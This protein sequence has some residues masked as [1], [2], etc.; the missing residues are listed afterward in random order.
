MSIE[1]LSGRTFGQYQLRELMGSGGM[2]AVYRAYQPAL[3]REVAFKVLSSV[4]ASHP[5]SIERFLREAQT[6][7]ALEHNHIV[8]I[9]D[10]GTYDNVT[11][12]VMRLLTGGSLAERMERQALTHQPLPTLIEI[13]GILN[14]LASALDYAHSQGV[15]HRDIKAS[16]VMFNNQG[17]AFLVDFGIVKL[18]DAT[19]SLTNENI[20]L[21]TPSYMS[22]EQWRGDPVTPAVDQYALGVLTYALVTGKLPFEAP[23]PY[24]MMHKHLNEI[25]TPP[26][27]WRAGLPVAVKYVL[28]RAM[29]KRPQERFPT[30]TAF[31][32][33]FAQ[34]IR[35]IEGQSTGFFT[36]PI[37]PTPVRS[38][39]TTSGT[40]ASTIGDS[41]R[42]RRNGGR[43]PLMVGLGVL[44]VAL[45]GIGIMFGALRVAPEGTPT[46]TATD[47]QENTQESFVL[48]PT[49]V[50]PTST[51][52]P[53]PSSTVTL[54][55]TNTPTLTASITPSATST[56]TSTA[57]STPKAEEIAGATYAAIQAA[58]LAALPATITPD[59]TQTLHAA[60]TAF[61]ERDLTLTATQWTSTPTPSPS[62]T[63]TATPTMIPVLPSATAPINVSV[64][65]N[66]VSWNPIQQTLGDA[67]M[68]L[69][70][71]GCFE[72]G[73]TQLEVDAALEQCEANLGAGQCNREWFEKESPTQQVCFQNPFW[74][75][76]LEVT[77]GQYGSSSDAFG[78]NNAQYPREN[79]SWFE[80]KSFCERRGAR[81]PTEAEW[82]YAARGPDGLS[83][84]WGDTFIADNS[85]Y[86]ANSGEHPANVGSRERGVSWVGALDMS[87]NI[88]EWT[89]TIFDTY[90]YDAND[91]RE[92]T[93]DATSQRVIRGGSWL[94]IPVSL[95][96]AD[97]AGIDPDVRDG[98]IGFRCLRD[99]QSH[100][101]SVTVVP[102]PTSQPPTATVFVPLIDCLGSPPSRLYVGMQATVLDTEPNSI[103]VRPQSAE[104]RGQ[105]FAGAI[106]NIIGGPQCDSASRLTWWQ[107]EYNGVTG[108]TAE[109]KGDVYWIGP[110]E[111]GAAT[112]PLTPIASANDTSISLPSCNVIVE[113][114]FTGADAT[115]DWY[116]GETDSSHVL[117]A[118]GAYE[119]TLKL[120][121]DQ[122]GNE[123]PISWGSLRG[124]T[125]RDVRV[126]AYITA[127]AFD[128]GE[129]RTG[130]W[131]RYQDEDHFLAFMIRS[132]G[133]FRISRYV[134]QPGPS[135]DYT[136]L[137]EWTFTDAVHVGD[138]VGNLLRIDV[139][140]D[141]FSFY[142]NGE[143]V[144][145]ATDNT[146]FE[147][148]MAF[149]GSSREISTFSLE[150]VRL[151]E[152]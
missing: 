51:D 67:E 80:A 128:T 93:S 13:S 105:I 88:R 91:G 48:L 3:R 124:F 140:G 2:G 117:I 33:T 118:D 97:R 1:N 6:A 72:M 125:F 62:F 35:G 4:L 94:V 78:G 12:V 92:D 103:R 21:G 52:T 71:P 84:P 79:V 61:Y 30:V 19:N 37:E 83:Y 59:T 44:L 47:I 126:D 60:L 123:T 107:V 142:I 101:L 102:A 135:N 150:Y 143:F 138:D 89:N 36:A 108:W 106:F 18:L 20:H 96:A 50:P 151:C 49:S 76:R 137:V 14:E 28:E 38:V 32:Q 144:A 90:P 136:D 73:S 31:A 23:T 147:G 7:A 55:P 82:E 66:N 134:L 152:N 63:P 42:F 64:A 65:T 34:A 53:L 26:Q 45:V 43:A 131:M 8:P 99:F 121:P 115:G 77:N 109:G 69:V 16:N 81:L 46:T 39:P 68:V 132:N 111:T 141:D 122:Q 87:G 98:N 25:P 24:A 127:T 17:E 119:I 40:P 22:P 29:A 139:N 110:V 148:R 54:P 57:T 11:F 15:I 104:I 116:Q 9:Y 129:D 74:I 5:E 149:W 133:S 113:D 75:D 100:E 56:N 130:I 146:W 114:D 10:F 70:P 145:S 112:M 27:T 86:E 85:V 120:S 95:R 41:E 58:T